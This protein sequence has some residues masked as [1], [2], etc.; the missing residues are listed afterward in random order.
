MLSEL[1]QINFEND[2]IFIKQIA[3]KKYSFLLSKVY[4]R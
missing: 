2:N 4:L 1:R 3:R